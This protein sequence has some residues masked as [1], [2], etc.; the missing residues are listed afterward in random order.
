MDSAKLAKLQ[1]QVRIGGK[2]TPR[3][4]QVK[5][6][7]TSSQGDSTKIQAALKKLGVSPITGV[8]EVNMFQ[9]DGN[10]LHFAAPKVAV[11][12]ALPSNTLAIYGRGQTKE[13]T[14]LVPGILNQLGPDS[15]ANL[16]RLAESYQSMTARQAAAAGEKKEGEVDADD[17][18]PDLVEN[19]DEADKKVADLEELE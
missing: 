2:G 6:S 1:A 3:R 15:L 10:V 11:H 19:F 4:K 7:V 12:A 18:I 17:E 5:K 16:R 13:L 9:E 14:E 8:E